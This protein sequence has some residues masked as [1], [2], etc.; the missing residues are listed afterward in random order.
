VAIILHQKGKLGGRYLPQSEGVAEGA[1]HQLGHLLLELRHVAALVG[2]GVVQQQL[3][4]SVALKRGN[5]KKPWRFFLTHTL[6][7]FLIF[8]CCCF[9]IFYKVFAVDQIQNAIPHLM[10]HHSRE[11][12][13]EV[14]EI[15]VAELGHDAGVQQHQLERTP[16]RPEA[17]HHRVPQVGEGGLTGGLPRCTGTVGGAGKRSPTVDQ[18][19]PGV[20]IS[21]DKVVHKHLEC[22]RIDGDKPRMIII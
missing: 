3:R 18:N 4:H 1:V 6:R 19:V 15:V 9:F 11:H 13:P 7:R 10:Q 20:E 8:C 22:R 16:V 5:Q 21:V 17:D 14:G 2:A 12:G